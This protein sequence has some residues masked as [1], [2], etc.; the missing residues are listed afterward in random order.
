M[1]ETKP[2]LAVF[3]H[4]HRYDRVYQATSILLSASSMGWTC[5]LFLFYDALASYLDGSWDEVN[6]TQYAAEDPLQAQPP[7][8]AKME[9]G[10]EAGNLP[11]LYEMLEKATREGGGTKIYACSTS[12]KVLDVDVPTVRKRVDEVVGL[13]TMLQVTESA[14]HVI[15]I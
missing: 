13:T 1:S 9:R 2:T 15:Y 3:L 6:I 8:L 14:N 4:S 11:S 7:W 5:H 10:F 12:C